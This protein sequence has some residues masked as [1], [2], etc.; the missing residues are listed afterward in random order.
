MDGVATV[1]AP[2]TGSKGG[3]SGGGVAAIVIIL[4][5]LAVAVSVAVVFIL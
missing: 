3:I 1:T 4:L 5:L 2:V